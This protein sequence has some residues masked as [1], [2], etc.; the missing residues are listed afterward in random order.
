MTDENNLESEQSY[1]NE[2]QSQETAERKANRAVES[3]S[4][5][6]EENLVHG[7]EM[8]EAPA[9][10]SFLHGLQT[11]VAWVQSLIN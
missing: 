7:A 8:L 10:G 3:G 1:T 11:F 4:E 9:D 2:G 6:T 5:D